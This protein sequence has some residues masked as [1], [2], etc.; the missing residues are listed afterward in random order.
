MDGSGLKVI[1]YF[2]PKDIS[3]KISGGTEARTSAIN[4]FSEAVTSSTSYN[5]SKI[6]YLTLGLRWKVRRTG[7]PGLPTALA[8]LGCY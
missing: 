3:A 5:P 6:F 7:P 2:R 1:I 4:F 8:P